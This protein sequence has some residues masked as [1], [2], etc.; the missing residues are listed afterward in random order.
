MV[1]YCCQ[2]SG[3]LW[4]TVRCAM[5]CTM[6][7]VL[8]AAWA[9]ISQASIVLLFFRQLIPLFVPKY[10]EILGLKGGLMVLMDVVCFG[11][12]SLYILADLT[13]QCQNY[14]ATVA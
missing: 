3:A 6:R 10:W 13:E 4:N 14:I 2:L 8:L 7:M 1:S 5:V 11:R 9:T 12:L